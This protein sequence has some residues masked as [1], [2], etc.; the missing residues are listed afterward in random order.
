MTAPS[1]IKIIEIQKK[2]ETDY[3]VLSDISSG[4]ATFNKFKKKLNIESKLNQF[5]IDLFRIRFSHAEFPSNSE[6]GFI[7]S[8]K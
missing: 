4:W 1:W 5:T 8:S 3:I 6:Q 2:T 7:I